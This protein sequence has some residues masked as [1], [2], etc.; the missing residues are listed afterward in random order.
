[1]LNIFS[2]AYWP[3]VCI[4]WRNVYFS[5]P[6][7]QLSCF[8]FLLLSCMSFL[9]ILEIKPLSLHIEKIFLPFCGLSF[10]FLMVS[11]AVQKHLSWIRPH[12]FI[13]VFI[14]LILGGRSKKM[15]PWFMLKNVLLMFSSRGFILSGLIF[16]SSIHF[17]FTVFLAQL[18]EETIFLPLYVLASFIIDKADHRCLGYFWAFYLFHWSSQDMEKT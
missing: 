18:F 5:L 12:W 13:F 8:L 15:L 6:F 2:C 10:L 16:R 11:L 17:K 14:D 3:S 7:F 4:L 9:Y 1:M